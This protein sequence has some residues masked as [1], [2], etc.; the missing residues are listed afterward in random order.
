VAVSADGGTWLPRLWKPL[1]WRRT[2]YSIPIELPLP[3]GGFTGCE[4]VG[5]N[6]LGDIV[7]D[8]WNEDYS[9]DVPTRWTTENPHFSEVIPFPLGGGYSW[10]VNN[11]RVAAITYWGGNCPASTCAGAVELK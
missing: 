7:G 3:E 6:D 5:L 1:N 4:S 8:C 11:R 9:V 2:E 10:G